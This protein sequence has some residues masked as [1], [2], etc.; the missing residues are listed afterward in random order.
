MLEFDV[1]FNCCGK[2]VIINATK[3]MKFAELALK[4]MDKF[5]IIA[6]DQPLFIYNSMRIPTDC[7]SLVGELK[8]RMS[9]RIYVFL[10]SKT[11]INT[12]ISKY[13][14]KILVI[15]FF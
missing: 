9:S 11:H 5:G 3:D 13:M 2:E 7:C 15:L 14:T 6:N 4:F 1:L 12:K 10:E 8:I